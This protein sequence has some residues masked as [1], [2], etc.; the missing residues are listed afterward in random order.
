MGVGARRMRA[1]F[2]AAKR[3]APCIVFIDE[4]VSQLFRERSGGG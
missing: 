1:L 3:K 4:I 2:Q